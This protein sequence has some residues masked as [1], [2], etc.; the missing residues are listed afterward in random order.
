MRPV[1]RT[2]ATMVATMVPAV[3]ASVVPTLVPAVV[4]TLVRTMLTVVPTLVRTMLTVVPTL[5]ASVVPT[6]V[7]PVIAIVFGSVA[8]AF[9][10]IVAV[11]TRVMIAALV[12]RL[13]IATTNFDVRLDLRIDLN[14]MIIVLTVVN[15]DVTAGV[16]PVVVATD[17]VRT[18]RGC[19]VGKR[20]IG[21][22]VAITGKLRITPLHTAVSAA[23]PARGLALLTDLLDATGQVTARGGQDGEDC[24]ESLKRIGERLH[25]RLD[26]TNPLG[27][28][29][30]NLL[31]SNR[32]RR[33]Q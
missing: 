20:P 12:G 21:I 2:T 10:V 32:S 6:I 30:G 22:P 14:V 4:P 7:R 26:P 23:S 16:D 33:A 3:V 5:V 28:P 1:V 29:A 25:D 8:R 24:L 9:T 19:T 27:D 15:V 13:F 18:A 31:R 11:V 17:I